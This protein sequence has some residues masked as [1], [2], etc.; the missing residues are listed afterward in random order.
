MFKTDLPRLQN[1]EKARLFLGGH[2]TRSITDNCFVHL[3]DGWGPFGD[4]RV[5]RIIVQLHDTSIIT[6]YPCGRVR[7]KSGGH[8]TAMTKHYLNRMSPFNVWSEGKDR[9]W[10]VQ[11]APVSS[12]ESVPTGIAFRDG[13][14]SN[15]DGMSWGEEF[16]R[17]GKKL[18]DQRAVRLRVLA[19]TEREKMRWD[20]V[21]V[22]MFAGDDEEVY[23]H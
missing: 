3:S 21:E 5:T 19:N 2:P 7:L 13:M 6:F 12:R 11:Y 17:R 4:T 8:T 18:D 20:Y 1:Y 15:D 9:P 23:S 14:L 10:A 16:H 22:D